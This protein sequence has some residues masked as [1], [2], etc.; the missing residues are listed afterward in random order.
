LSNEKKTCYE[1]SKLNSIRTFVFAI[2]SPL[3]WDTFRTANIINKI[4]TFS[5]LFVLF[6]FIILFF[7]ITHCLCQCRKFFFFL[8]K[9]QAKRYL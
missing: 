9:N 1:R 8:L 5:H 4:L 7:C 2:F 6:I 3:D